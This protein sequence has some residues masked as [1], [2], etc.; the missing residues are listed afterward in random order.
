MDRTVVQFN[1][2]FVVH[3]T[4]IAYRYK[5]MI[6]FSI[7]AQYKYKTYAFQQPDQTHIHFNSK[8]IFATYKR[9][10]EKK[11]PFL[12]PYWIIHFII[13]LRSIVY[14]NDANIVWVSI[15]IG[16]VWFDLLCCVCFLFVCVR[17]CLLSFQFDN[18]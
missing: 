13:N 5:R 10:I 18:I 9:M 12:Q 1:T 6:K 8:K 3:I 15:K 16:L 2:C 17:A 11:Y 14:I 7:C 4:H